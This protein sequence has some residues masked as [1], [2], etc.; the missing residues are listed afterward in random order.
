[1]AVDNYLT[2]KMI[3]RFKLEPT[4]CQKNLFDQ[5]SAFLSADPEKE[6]MMVISGYAGTGKTSALAS[7]I[8]VL[9]EYG[10][11]Y[12][13]LAPTGRAAKVLSNFTGEVAKTI[14]KQIYRQKSLADGLGLFSL[15]F[16][17]NKETVFIVD[18]VSL[19]SAQSENGSIFGT[20][21]VLS[22]LITYVRN[23]TSNRLVLTGDPAQLPPVGL[24]KSP[25]LDLDYLYRYTHNIRSAHLTSVVRQAHESGILYNATLL[26]N[27][28]ESENLDAPKFCLKK[29]TDIEKITGDRLI[30]KISDSIDKYGMDDVVVLCRSNAR[31]NK[32][33]LGIRAQVLYREEQLSRGDKLMIV[34]NCYQFENQSKDLDFIA[35]GDVAELIKISNYTERYNLHFAN[36]T[37]MFPDYNKAEVNAKIILDTLTSTS[38][39]LGP[40]QQR[41]LYHAV[42]EDYSS[43]ENKRKRNSAVR[44]DPF[45][46]A[47]QVKYSTAITGHKS[48]GGQWRCVFIDNVLWRDDI[49]LDDK[50]WLYTAITRA[51]EKVYLVNFA[52]KFIEK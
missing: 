45:F 51:V 36:A 24:E 11:K 50:K 10:Y 14:H 9:K 43:I 29:F 16:N 8:G 38:A 23:D 39:A 4:A 44:E 3:K 26:R 19:L 12:V 47:L 28:I 20:G 46:N 6:W 17:K 34:K 37:L 18:E 40:D 35:N 2:G 1:M 27:D 42:Y 13:L 31:A 5:M 41:E 33:N 48:Q 49:T 22:D 15:D 52:D 30:E 21:N 25:A 7:F 32:Y